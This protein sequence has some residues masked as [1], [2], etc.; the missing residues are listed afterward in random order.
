MSRG[1]DQRAYEVWSI[2]LALEEVEDQHEYNRERAW[3][4]LQRCLPLTPEQRSVLTQDKQLTAAMLTVLKI[5]G[6]EA[7]SEFVKAHL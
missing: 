7:A 1:A 5:S 3:D 4:K 6:Q 2:N